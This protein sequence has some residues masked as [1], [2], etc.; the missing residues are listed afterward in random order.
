MGILSLLKAQNGLTWEEMR[1]ITGKS[2]TAMQNYDT[3][4]RMIPEDV[5]DRLSTFFGISKEDLKSGHTKGE[6]MILT[7]ELLSRLGEESSEPEVPDAQKEEQTVSQATQDTAEAAAVKRC[8]VNP[9]RKTTMRQEK[10]SFLDMY[11]QSQDGQGITVGKI[12]EK[13]LAAAP[14]ATVIYVKPEDNRAYWTGDGVMGNIR[15]WG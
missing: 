12:Y 6:D 1:Q 5:Y 15:L 2:L 7:E 11:I 14:L 10:T 9:R 3:K 8:V 4:G 13:V